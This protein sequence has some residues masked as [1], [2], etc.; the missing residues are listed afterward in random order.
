MYSPAVLQSGGNI[1]IVIRNKSKVT[2]KNGTIVDFQYGALVENSNEVKMSFIKISNS[3]KN[4]IDIHHS[5]KVDLSFNNISRSGEKGIRIQQNSFGVSIL[6][7]SVSESGYDGISIVE[8]S[9]DVSIL[10]SRISG[11]GDVGIGIYENSSDVSILNSTVTDNDR[12][13]IH[14]VDSNYNLF[15]GNNISRNGFHGLYLYNSNNNTICSNMIMNNQPSAI[16]MEMGNQ[17]IIYHNNFLG[18]QNVVCVT[19]KSAWDIGYGTEGDIGYGGNYW[20]D[21]NGI[22]VFSGKNQNVS[23]S[24]GIGDAAREIDADNKDRYPLLKPWGSMLMDFDL[25]C[26]VCAK[27][28]TRQVGVFSDA[29]I[30]NFNFNR[31]EGVISFTADNGTFC[32]LI[33]PEEALSGSFL[34]T[35]NDVPKA[36]ISYWDENHHFINFS[37]SLES[38]N[39]KIKGETAITGDINGDGIVDI[40]DITLVATNFGAET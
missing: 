36:C 31:T 14:I 1:G 21:Y 26:I 20:D 16:Y 2:I 3:T 27:E 37:L 23:G 33:I 19:S 28:E 29:S 7:N 34:V 15:S 17:N 6:N 18:Q 5:E 10:N 39:V 12:E 32:K 35:V 4:G 38:C 30:A 8:D 40:V 25:D 24:D 9:S 22:D 11:S 13:G